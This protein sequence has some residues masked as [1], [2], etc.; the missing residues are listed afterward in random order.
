[1]EINEQEQKITNSFKV[2]LEKN[3]D[4]FIKI[5]K[6]DENFFSMKL[7][8]KYVDNKE[9]SMEDIELDLLKTYIKSGLGKKIN[10]KII[11]SDFQLTPHIYDT[12]NEENIRGI[13][14]RLKYQYDDIIPFK[15][16]DCAADLEWNIKNNSVRFI[17]HN[18]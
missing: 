10:G 11:V 14:V 6:F 15:C 18:T 2:Y 12:S 8:V 4:E 1:M 13:I 16:P 7:H 9:V 3:K 17:K 5:D